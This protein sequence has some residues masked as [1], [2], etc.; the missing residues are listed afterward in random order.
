MVVAEP[1]NA[2]PHESRCP[3]RLRNAMEERILATKAQI[4]VEAKLMCFR[5]CMD[6]N[7]ADECDPDDAWMEEARAALEA[8]ETKS[9]LK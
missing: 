2:Q 1:A 7:S 3:F 9:K 5:A 4:R 8:D 6:C